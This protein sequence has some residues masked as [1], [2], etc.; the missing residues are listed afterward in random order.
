M[1]WIWF[2]IH[3]RWKK[4]CFVV[5][6]RLPVLIPP[7]KIICTVFLRLLFLNTSIN[8]RWYTIGRPKCQLAPGLPVAD[9]AV[10]AT[11]V[12]K[13]LRPQL[14]ALPAPRQVFLAT[15]AQTLTSNTAKCHLCS[16]IHILARCPLFLA[17]APCERRF[18]STPL[19]SLF[20]LLRPR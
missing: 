4:F 2:E 6:Q 8:I 14:K 19:T 16:S 11:P 7:R 15:A 3:L 13:T 12:S 10:R 9:V 18:E 20:Q 1:Q 5:F 17:K